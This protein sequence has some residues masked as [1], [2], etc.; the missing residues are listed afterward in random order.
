VTSLPPNLRWT[1]RDLDSLT[2]GQI[3]RLT[4]RGELRHILAGN[5]LPQEEADA[6]KEEYRKEQGKG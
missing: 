6:L 3:K 2:P 5:E 4:E 1:S